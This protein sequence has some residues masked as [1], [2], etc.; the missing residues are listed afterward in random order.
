M[1][2]IKNVIGGIVVAIL[3]VSMYPT[4]AAALTTANMSGFAGAIAS[5]IY[6]LI[7]LGVLYFVLKE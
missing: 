4:F 2:A 5:L 6:G 1:D 3:W 7:G